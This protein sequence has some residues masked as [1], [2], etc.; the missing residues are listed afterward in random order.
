MTPDQRLAVMI[1]GGVI[2]VA[3]L[4]LLFLKK[5]EGQNRLK[6]FGQEFEIST[7]SLVVFLAGCGIFV[8]PFFLPQA[9]VA[10]RSDI[11]ATDNLRID[12]PRNTGPEESNT[13]VLPS[14]PTGFA[15]EPNDGIYDATAILF[16]SS[17][18]GKLT[19]RDPIDWYVFKTPDDVGDQVLVI[20]RH[21]EGNGIVQVDVYDANENRIAG[22]SGYQ[23][24]HS[25][26][27]RADKKLTYYVKVQA[28]SVD[29]ENYEL[30]VR[31]KSM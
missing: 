28:N 29:T 7:P 8:M 3:S 22:E 1:F 18:K 5:E 9:N 21:V 2:V 13:V 23:L 19:Q 30:A 11:A 24:G 6:V 31:N 27:I 17:I 26:S 15:K 12:H 4:F 20:Y 25:L 14:H 10:P 16:G